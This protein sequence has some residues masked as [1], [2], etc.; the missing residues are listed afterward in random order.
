MSQFGITIQIFIPSGNPDGMKVI[1]KSQWTGIGLYFP[2]SVFTDVLKREELSRTGVYI[3]WDP[4]GDGQLPRAY[5][6][7]G[8]SLTD[9]FI[10][11]I[12]NKEFWTHGVAFTN[13]DQNL[14]KAHVKYLE[15]RL[16]ELATKAKKCK[17]DNN[18]TPQLPTLSEADTANT[19]L[20]LENLLQC[21]PIVGIHCFEQSKF[22]DQINILLFASTKTIKASG[23]EDV[24]GFIVRSGSGIVKSESKTIPPHVSG[25]R[26]ILLENKVVHDDGGKYEF[27]EDY[28]FSSPSTAAGVV[29]GRSAN[30]RTEWK[31]EKGVTLRDIQTIASESVDNET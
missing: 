23:Y 12:K 9:R 3:L 25:I 2:R 19:E 24:D 31:D 28:K 15:A 6:G 11:H 26:K 13:K 22:Q 18:Q 27:I 29:L 21:L 8:G 1:E 10:S 16:V 4:T 20:Y 7:E 17:L 14:N 30:G 5:I